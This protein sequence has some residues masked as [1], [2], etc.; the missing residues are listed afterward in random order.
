MTVSLKQ[1]NLQL[2]GRKN[3]VSMAKFQS[4]RG[5][6]N[7]LAVMD[8]CWK[9]NFVSLPYFSTEWFRTSPLFVVCEVLGFVSVAGLQSGR[10]ATH[11]T[12]Q[13]II[14]GGAIHVSQP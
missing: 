11:N 14:K 6:P 10:G 7:Q 9:F 2:D 3:V 5:A 1:V 4:A 8:N 12:T 13:Q